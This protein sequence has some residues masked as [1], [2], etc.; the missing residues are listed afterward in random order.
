MRLPALTVA[1]AVAL[2][3]ACGTDPIDD[4]HE[5]DTR[6]TA[7]TMVN[8]TLADA[9]ENAQTTTVASVLD[10]IDNAGIVAAGMDDRR[11]MEALADLSVALEYA[12][13]P[14]AIEAAERVD[15]LCVG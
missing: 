6:A 7:C 14:G 11:L 8:G 3:G 1:L 12:D 2:L 15:R 5:A 9:S 13:E 10:G 4:A